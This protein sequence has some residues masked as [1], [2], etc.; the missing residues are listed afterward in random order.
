MGTNDPLPFFVN[1]DDSDEP[2]DVLDSLALG[3]FIAGRHPI[4]QARQLSRVRP[5]ATLVPASSTSCRVAEGHWRTVVLSEGFGWILKAVSF[6]DNTAYLIVTATD[7]PLA[8]AILAEVSAD[9]IEPPPPVGLSIRVG[10]WHLGA[11]GPQR[12]ARPIEV[13]PWASVRR[14]YTETAASA[15]D[16][17]MS[18]GPA[19]LTGRLLAPARTARH[20]EDQCGAGHRPRMARLVHHGLRPRP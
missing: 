19:K 1:V 17:V 16:E 2:G 6:R 9:A 5:D 8:A 18:L 4:A 14:N 7:K 10:F 12:S 15:L 13:T 20:R 11:R 3:P